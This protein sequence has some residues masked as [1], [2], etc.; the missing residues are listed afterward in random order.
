MST[1]LQDVKHKVGPSGDY[2]YFELDILDAINEAFA[3]LTQLG[4]G[5]KEGFVVN[6]ETTWEDYP[7]STVALGMIKTY[8]YKKTVLIF[9]PPNNGSHLEVIKD[10]IAELEWRLNV[11]VDPGG[12]DE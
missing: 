9:D 11:L 2:E 10:K 8:I 4:V 12:D 7:E 1:I 3:I 6:S 5:P